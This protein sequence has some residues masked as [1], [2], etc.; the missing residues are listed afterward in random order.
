MVRSNSHLTVISI[1]HTLNIHLWPREGPSK[2]DFHKD[3]L[4][5]DH[6]VKMY[7]AI[8]DGRIKY[9]LN[10]NMV[11]TTAVSILFDKANL[12]HEL[13]SFSRMRLLEVSK[14]NVP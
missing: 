6:V 10:L 2:G 5:S 9:T 11:V 8:R 14:H 1:Y 3:L 13:T 7:I 4:V 12:D